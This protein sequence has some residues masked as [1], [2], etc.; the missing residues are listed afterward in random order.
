LKTMVVIDGHWSIQWPRWRY[1]DRTILNLVTK[2]VV[3]STE[4]L[5][6]TLN[7]IWFSL[8]GRTEHCL[9]MIWTTEKFMSFLHGSSVVLDLPG[10]YVSTDLTI[11]LMFSCL[12]SHFLDQ[13]HLGPAYIESKRIRWGFQ[14]TKNGTEL[15]KFREKQMLFE[16]HTTSN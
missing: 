14:L 7:G 1:L 2:F 8:L 16:K 4:W 11:F 6:F 5:Q 3:R 10:V 15:R 12:W 13:R 9:H